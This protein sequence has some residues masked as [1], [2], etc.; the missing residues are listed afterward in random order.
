[1]KEEIF[2]AFLS[3]LFTKGAL[4]DFKINEDYFFY[5]KCYGDLVSFQKK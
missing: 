4:S 5:M 1:M 2:Q 3:I